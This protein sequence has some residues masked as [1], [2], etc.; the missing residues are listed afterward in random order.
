MISDL[1]K[2]MIEC[3]GKQADK[4]KRAI[5]K[6]IH[7]NN[8]LLIIDLSTCSVFHICLFE[9]YGKKAWQF[10]SKVS[11]PKKVFSLLYS[12]IQSLTSN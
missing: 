10:G 11:K 2:D 8:Q 12:I 9:D 1:H 6:Y 3:A 7:L 4:I 5:L